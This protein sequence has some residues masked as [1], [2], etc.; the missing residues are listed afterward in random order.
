MSLNP[1]SSN[2]IT[3]LREFIERNG[4]KIEGFIENY[5]RYSLKK[6]K[7]IIFTIKFPVLLPIRINIPF[8]VVSFRVALAFQIWNLD[9]NIY[10]YILYFM[11][12]LRNLALSLDLEHHF[13]IQGKEQ[14]LLNLLKI[15]LPELIKDENESTWLNRIRISLM[16]KR[17]KF[18][19]FSSDILE[20]IVQ[21]LRRTG[22][23]PS[24]KVP[25]ELKQGV[26]KIRT[27]ETLLFSINDNIEEFFI[28]EKG[29][30]TYLKDINYQKLHIRSLFDTYSPYLLNQLFN[31]VPD[32]KLEIL[33]EN[34]VKFSRI[35]LKSVIEIIENGNINLNEFINFRLTKELSFYSKNF[36]LDNNNFPY[37]ALCY[38]S[39]IAK[40]TFS[41]RNNLFNKPPTNFEVI[42]S[43]N[44]YT[45]AEELMNNYR[46]EEATNLL[47]EALKV[48]NKNQQKKAVVSILLKLNKIATLLNKEEIALNYLENAL[49]IAKSGE[50]PIDIIIKIHY[51]LG[52]SYFKGKEFENALNHFNVIINFL[53]QEKIPFKKEEYL[54]LTYLY[55]GLIC[56]EQKK[57]V[58]AKNNFKKTVQIGNNS[59]KTRLKYFLLRAKYFKNQGNLSQT[60]KFL[61]FGI[62]SIGLEFNNEPYKNI[63][64][65]LVLELAEFYIHYRKDSKKAIYLLKTVEN[66]FF[67]KEIRD[68]RR[69][70]RWNLLMSDY[71]NSVTEDRK[72][73]QF[74]LKQSQK[75]K[76]QL[77]T[78]GVNE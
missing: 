23:K 76:I 52:K 13:P 4:W 34:W 32:F 58:D 9:Q 28:L 69:A 47:N 17:D 19:K 8:E 41:I 16:N 61:R 42:E 72:N 49:G 50:I 33:V 63:L 66:H 60:Q 74:Y 73:S 22:L 64:I 37:S 43:I 70:I 51:K 55:S 11:K 12:A 36:I 40:E 15:L 7:I 31:D 57:I 77:Q 68:I 75:L 65:D 39:S 78:I 45:N 2:E 67:P 38:E 29:Y 30:F 35:I 59:I 27:S 44:E 24:F 46:F 18:N 3:N 48:F 5:F 71:Y 20:R 53:E 54:G 10:N 56:L 1:F 21:S 62:N 14:N 25:W 26:P 6:E